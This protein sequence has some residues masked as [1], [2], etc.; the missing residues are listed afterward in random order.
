[1]ITKQEKQKLE[2]SK[3]HKLNKIAK[4]EKVIEDVYGALE[5]TNRGRGEK[6]AALDFNPFQLVDIMNID[7]TN[8]TVIVLLKNGTVVSWGEESNTLGRKIIDYKVDTGIPMQIKNLSKITDLV[9]GREHCLAKAVDFKIY[10][11]GSNSY[12]Q[13]F[14]YL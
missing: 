11:W 13:V 6:S 10:S 1:M 4:N 14:F 12:G 8:K 3:K 7:C 5:I 2:E 9:C